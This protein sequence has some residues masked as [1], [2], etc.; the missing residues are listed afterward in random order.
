MSLFRRFKLPKILKRKQSA[1]ESIGNVE[2]FDCNAL[3]AKKRLSQGSFGDVST[4]ECRA[5]GNVVVVKKML[6]VLDQ[7]EKKLFF[8][9]VALLNRLSH[10]NVVKL[11]G[12]C[13]QPAAIMLEYVFFDFNL[14]GE[15]NLHVSSLSD[16][17]SIINDCNCD[18]FHDLVN[19]A[20]VEIKYKK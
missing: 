4:T 3:P 7:D 13:H 5:A 15:E 14:F 19:H 20:A 12:V 1:L 16:F 6:Q 9:E 8:K 18:G 10:P 17:L 2:T 11:L